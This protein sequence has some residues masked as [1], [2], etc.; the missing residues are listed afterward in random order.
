MASGLK[1]DRRGLRRLVEMA[2]RR[3]IDAV[4]VAYTA[5]GAVRRA[6]F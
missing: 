6:E 1:E 2:K 3:E 4:V 5:S